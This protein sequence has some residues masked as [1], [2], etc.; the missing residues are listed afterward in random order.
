[1]LA[2]LSGL[3]TETCVVCGSDLHLYH[4]ALKGATPTAT[5]PHPITGET[6]PVGLGHEYAVGLLPLRRHL[7]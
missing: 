4:G 6:L 7:I 3:L 1:M 2:C 5:E